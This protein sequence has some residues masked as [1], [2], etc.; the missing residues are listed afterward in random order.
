M[1]ILQFLVGASFAAMH[2]FVSYSV[3]VT[4]PYKIAT[5]VASS[6]SSFASKATDTASVSSFAATVSGSVFPWLNKMVA[7]AAGSSGVAQNVLNERGES[8][9]LS[10]GNAVEHVRYTTQQQKVHCL[11]TSGQAFAIW[12]NCLYLAPLTGLFV[13]FFVK[14]YVFGEPRTVRSDKKSHSSRRLSASELS[15]SA[16][17]QTSRSVEAMG[18]SVERSIETMGREV[19][20]GGEDLMTQE[21]VRRKLK[22]VYV[23]SATTT[24][25]EKDTEEAID[26][27]EVDDDEGAQVGVQVNGSAH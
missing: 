17:K 20:V 22:E 2:L 11:D 13:R 14:A 10:K 4:V 21:D 12:L 6:A 23:E 9:G 25:D 8:F 19:E 5:G 18:R 24:S 27:D 16:W 3:P 7:W 15:M 1:Q 26:D